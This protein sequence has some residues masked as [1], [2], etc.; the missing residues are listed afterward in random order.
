LLNLKQRF[1]S[2]HF[3]CRPKWSFMVKSTNTYSPQIP[4]HTIH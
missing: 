2:L 3:T 4:W 1:Q